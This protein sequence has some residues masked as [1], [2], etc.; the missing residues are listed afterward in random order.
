M[1]AFHECCEI[2]LAELEDVARE[3]FLLSEDSIVNA[4]HKII[5]RLENS[6]FKALS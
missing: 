1:I 3:R 2:L 6:V 5:N 4:R